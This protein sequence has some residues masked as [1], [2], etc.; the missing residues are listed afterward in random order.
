MP[1]DWHNFFFMIAPVSAGIGVGA[2]AA[3]A[4]ATATDE[5]IAAI[6]YSL[7]GML[8]VSLMARSK[9]RNGLVFW[10]LACAAFTINMLRLYGTFP[11]TE[12]MIFLRALAGL[13]IGTA[14]AG[15]VV[16]LAQSCFPALN[17][18]KGPWT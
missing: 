15:F 17:L 1:K 6:A 2:G 16:E 9:I 5:L 14:L 3:T 12:A 10:G 18:L 13:T 4:T 11:D 8:I 7:F